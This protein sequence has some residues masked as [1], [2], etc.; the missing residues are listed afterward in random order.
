MENFHP[1][2]KLLEKDQV[3]IRQY[4]DGKVNAE[5]YKKNKQRSC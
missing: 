1:L 5:K 2:L 4:K 3:G